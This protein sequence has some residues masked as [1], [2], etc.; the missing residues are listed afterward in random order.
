MARLEAEE[1]SLINDFLSELGMGWENVAK[2]GLWE[3]A[4]VLKEGLEREI[5]SLPTIS[6]RYYFGRMMPMPALRETEKRGLKEGLRIFR[7]QKTADGISATIG[8]AGY[9]ANGKANRLI[10][11]SLAAGSTANKPNRFVAKAFKANESRR[12]KAVTD[13]IYSIKMKEV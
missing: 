5:D 13:K 6:D 12:Y 3:G 2:A 4:A 10:A 8:F 9:N 1:I 11:R 7:F